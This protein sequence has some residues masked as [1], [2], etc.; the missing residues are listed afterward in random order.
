MW[1]LCRKR[2][3]VA[4]YQHERER[5]VSAPEGTKAALVPV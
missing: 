5:R 1:M 3:F 2:N 4:A